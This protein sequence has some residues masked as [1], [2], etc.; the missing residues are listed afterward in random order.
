MTHDEFIQTVRRYR[1][2]MMMYKRTKHYV[3]AQ[4]IISLEKEIDAA[5]ADYEA[6]ERKKQNIEIEFPP[7]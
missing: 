5:I 7:F 6:E 4:K 2:T 3:Y 1:D